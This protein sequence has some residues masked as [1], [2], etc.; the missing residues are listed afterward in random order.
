[1][2]VCS[3][4]CRS[5]SRTGEPSGGKGRRRSAEKPPAFCTLNKQVNRSFLFVAP[6]PTHENTFKWLIDQLTSIKLVFCYYFQNFSLI[7]KLLVDMMNPTISRKL[8]TLNF[9]K[10]IITKDS[11]AGNYLPRLLLLMEY[12]Y[13][14]IF[15]SLIQG[16]EKPAGLTSVYRFLLSCPTN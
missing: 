12:F 16:S 7:D 6:T 14:P 2:L 3:L 13:L 9:D 8:D 4:C 15:M 11:L 10:D 5:G 1:M